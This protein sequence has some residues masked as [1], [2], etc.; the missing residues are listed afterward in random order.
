[1]NGANELFLIAKIFFENI[2]LLNDSK[3]YLLKKIDIAKYIIPGTAAI[4]ASRS[5]ILKGI[6]S[7]I[8]ALPNE[9]PNSHSPPFMGKPRTVGVLD[10]LL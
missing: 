7:H 8:I 4:K 1:L 3:V 2:A 6:T 5:H 9:T 10:R